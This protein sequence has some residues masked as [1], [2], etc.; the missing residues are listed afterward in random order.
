MHSYAPWITNTIKI[1]ENLSQHELHVISPHRFIAG[2]KTFDIRGICYHFFNPGIPGWGRQWP[3]F[4]RWDMLTGYRD[5]SRIIN[6][7][8]DSIE[9]DIIHLQGAENPYYSSS[10][11][12]LR[13]RYPIVV[14]LQR[15]DPDFQF[16]NTAEAH[17]RR[18]IEQSI[19]KGFEYFSIRTD[20]MRRDLLEVNP[21]A[22]TYWVPYN[23]PQPVSCNEPKEYDLVY[24]ARVSKQKGIE[25]LIQAAILLKRDY[26][27]ISLCVIGGVN[28]NYR[29]YL[30]ELA[31]SGGIQLIWKG[32]LPEI[33]AVHREAC[34]ARISVLPTH[35]D[36]I[37]G[38]IV[39]SMQLGLPVVSYKVG[40]IPELNLPTESVLLAEKGD[41]GGLADN[42][43]RLLA[44]PEYAAKLVQTAKST[45][46]R[47]IGAHNVLEKHL[48]CYESV[49]NEFKAKNW[50]T[51]NV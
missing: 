32:L 14:N 12:H 20:T 50:T 38:T 33:D 31:Q 43:K 41:I 4:F 27:N 25:D 44:D 15:M 47:F 36:I 17:K 46:E 37:P 6:K 28:P 2:C 29:E 10:I 39:E 5:N 30:D 9:P 18:A 23:I 49:I 13:D 24:F 48:A 21:T 34:K 51:D 40:S 26:P 22:K 3:S 8:I 1:F 11:F 42:I 16:G 19:V 35:Q 45:I 7:F